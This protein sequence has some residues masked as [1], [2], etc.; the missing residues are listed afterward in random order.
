MTRSTS[1]LAVLSVLAASVLGVIL[2]RTIP[3]AVFPEMSFHRATILADSGDLPAEQMLASVT[4][5][6][7]EAAYGVA[8][9]TLVRSTTTRGSAEIDVTFGEDADPQTSFQM[10]NAAIAHTRSELPNE[11]TVD[12]RLLTTGTFPIVELSLS[13]KVRSLPELTDIVNYDLVPS[14][15]RIAG[16]YRV[17][18]IGGKY[19][20]YV[21]RLDP[22]RML[23]HDMSP[24][25]VVAGLAKDN[26]I[27]SAG[28]MNESH[29]MLLTV[30]TTDLH[31]ADQ[32]AAVPLTAEGSNLCA[33]ATSGAS[34]WESRRITS[35]PRPRMAPPCW[36]ES[37]G[38]Q[39]AARSRSRPQA[40][41]DTGR[42]SPALSGRR[43]FLFLRSGGPGQRIVQQR[44]RR[45]RTRPR[46]GGAGGAG[47]HDEP[48]ERAGRCDRGAVHHRD[49][50]HRDEA[51]GHDLQHDDAGRTGGGNRAVHRRR[52]R[53][54]RGDP[55]RA[56]GG[57]A[58]GDCRGR[59]AQE[60]P[61]SAGRLDHDGDRRVRA[62]GFH[63]GRDRRFLPLAGCDARRRTGHFA[64]SRD[65][66]HAGARARDR[67]FSRTRARSGAAL[68]RR[69]DRVPDDGSTVCPVPVLAIPVAIGSALVA[70]FVYD[71][72][73]TD[74]LPPLDEGA[75]ILDYITPPQSTM[76]DTTALLDS[77]QADSENHARSRCVQPPHRHATRI[78]PDRIES[79]RHL[80]AA[81]GGPQARYRRQS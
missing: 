14:L 38:G 27:E 61:A 68:S 30:V 49:H 46:A 50:V 54:D 55:S 65:L 63:L 28:R 12:A 8:G 80:G 22:A 71:N 62:A 47:I 75:F 35:A 13:S 51:G 41:A 2:A 78:F 57:S 1:T 48:A 40:R 15:H 6:L 77:I 44:A 10:L 36:W 34:N 3:S 69:S 21:V 39:A 60:S 25:D 17:G 72:I 70:Y 4:R 33:C 74:Y 58:G 64:D 73:G 16:I 81:E 20:E 43:F 76:A 23:Q 7:E 53:D 37:R 9:V 31:E 19:R 29:R 52:D 45:D 42:F 66:F 26:V 56:R 59:S 67:A 5:P 24:A 79:R 18:V 11:T 32:I